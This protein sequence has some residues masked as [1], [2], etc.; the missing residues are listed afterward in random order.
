NPG[1]YS[2]PG[3]AKNGLFKF[4]LWSEPESYEEWLRDG[5][6]DATTTGSG[7]LRHRCQ[8][9]P[10]GGFQNW[11]RRGEHEIRGCS[12][13]RISPNPVVVVPEFVTPPVYSPL[14]D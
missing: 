10:D 13:Q 6:C 4:A 1:L 7:N 11:N 3:H 12:Q 9:S 14:L 5:P 8:L 2:R